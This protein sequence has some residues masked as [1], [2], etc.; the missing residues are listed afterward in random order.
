MFLFL[1]ST[2]FNKLPKKFP[3]L[4]LMVEFFSAI[5]AKDFNDLINLFSRM[6]MGSF[7]RFNRVATFMILM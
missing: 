1:V 5:G 7:K 2:Q 3:T 6:I 4:G